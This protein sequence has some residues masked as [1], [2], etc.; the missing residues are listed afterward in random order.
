MAGFLAG[1]R[2]NEQDT[3]KVEEATESVLTTG[4][5]DELVLV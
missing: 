4:K 2:A 5:E 3:P 1:V